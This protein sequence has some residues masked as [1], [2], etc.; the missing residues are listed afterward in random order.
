M[1]LDFL[2]SPWLHCEQWCEWEQEKRQKE[3]SEGYFG[4]E[5]MMSWFRLVALMM[6]NRQSQ[7]L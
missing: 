1:L 6:E 2:K 5:R 7:E 3:Q 4:Q